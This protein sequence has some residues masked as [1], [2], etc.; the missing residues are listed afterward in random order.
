MMLPFSG[1]FWLKAAVVVPVAVLLLLIAVSVSMFQFFSVARVQQFADG[2]LAGSQRSVRFDANIG[3]SLFPRPTLTLNNLSISEPG[4]SKA[5]LTVAQM[6]IGLGWESLWQ[7]KPV[8][9]KWVVRGAD[10][11][12]ARSDK[13]TWNV[14]DLWQ[15]KGQAVVNRV[16]VEDSRI[17]VQLPLYDDVLEGFSL[18]VDEAESGHRPFRMAGRLKHGN[19]PL[20]WQGSGVLRQIGG[21]DWEVPEF[22]LNVQGVY[23]GDTV[24]VQSS[25]ALKWLPHQGLLQVQNVRA[26]AD[27]TFQNLHVSVQVPLLLLGGDHVNMSGVR[28]AFTGGVR[29]HQWDGSFKL[30]KANMRPSVAAFDGW[31]VNGRHQNGRVQTS[32]TVGAPLVWQQNQGVQ[33]DALQISTL[34]DNISGTPRPRFNSQLKGRLKVQNGVWQ[35]DLGGTFDRQP[36]SA[37]F[38]YR[39]AEAGSRAHFETGVAL[40][41]LS[42]LPYWHD[43]ENSGEGYPA[44]LAQDWMPEIEAQLKIGGIQFPGLQV[45]R[46]ET[47]LAANRDHIA[48]SN[49]QAELY[50]GRTEGGISV[51][52]TRPVSYRLQQNAHGVQVRPLLQDLFGFHRISGKG[53]AL[54]DL[55]AK[56]SG[57]QS[58]MQSLAGSMSLNLYQG[59]WHGIDLDHILE[60]GVVGQNAQADLFTPFHR[61]SIHSEIEQ[62][63]SRHEGSELLSDSLYVS[64][65][66]YTDLAKQ[67]ISE[68]LQIRNRRQPLSK[69]VPLKIS[70]AVE[71]PS[72]TIDYRRLTDGLTTPEE[73]QKALENTLREQW[74][75]LKPS[76]P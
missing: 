45:D 26:R 67:E 57:R 28:G 71:N 52:N 48:L 25:S 23:G 65:S 8:V 59:A 53:D 33:S 29:E 43:V 2:L 76:K 34:Q 50:G 55:S 16:V 4:S 15:E 41:K 5:A 32:F 1:K 75:W 24:A 47:R 63:I 10:V 27:T 42:L 66:G 17:H 3:R 56:G 21:R 61:F 60:Q 69:P 31:E 68:T 20:S 39:A 9:E 7:G 74:Q 70:G 11:R 37:V 12:L 40:N 62:G 51:A 64:G 18:N 14:R 36:V 54:I 58:L 73:K 44:V 49:F 38:R 6:Q 46:V 72:V 13:H 19:T 22:G 35:G 30:D